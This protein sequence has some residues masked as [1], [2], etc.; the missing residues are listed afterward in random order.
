MML[1]SAR[2]SRLSVSVA[3]STSRAIS[4]T[5]RM[6]RKMANDWSANQYLK[7]EA[8]RTRP[9]RDLLV[10]VPFGSPKRVVDL[11]CGPGNSTAVLLS[12]YPDARVTGMDSSPDMIKKAR[13]TLPDIDFTVDDL[14]TYTPA[15][16]VDLFF[17]NAVFQWLPRSE[18]LQVVKRLIEAQPSG[19]VFAFQVPDNLTEPSHVAMR[20]TAADGPWASSLDT[21][22]RDTFQTPQ[23][24]YD[25]LKPVCADVNVWHTHYYHSLDGHEAVVE[26]VKGTG[27]RPFI[28]PLSPA[29]RD[30][31]LKSYLGRIEKAYPKAIDGRVLLR[32]PRLFV[33][34][35]RK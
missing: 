24:I 7:F 31:F 23:E 22:G 9:S 20:E 26:W 35:V 29:D 14:T 13:A 1:S 34:A 32:Y 19:G 27:L 16:P 25:E 5:S 15:E 6:T 11:G 33:V 8:E 3:S 10:Q 21:A 2:I 4:S 17:S 18:R 28:D 30:A 12:Q